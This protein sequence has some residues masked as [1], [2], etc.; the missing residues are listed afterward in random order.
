MGN[1]CTF[2]ATTQGLFM[3]RNWIEYP[4]PPASSKIESQQDW[5]DEYRRHDKT[6]WIELHR[7]SEAG[8]LALVNRFSYLFPSKTETAVRYD[9][10][11]SGIR[12]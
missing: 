8:D 9:D 11:R 5:W 1:H 4:M 12:R 2:T 10:P 7:V 6:W 3:R